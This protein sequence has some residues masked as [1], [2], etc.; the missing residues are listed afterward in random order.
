MHAIILI[1]YAFLTYVGLSAQSISELEQQP[2]Q[3][4]SEDHVFDPSFD[5]FV[6]DLLR[7]LHV[8][9]LSVA[10]VDN[11]KIA[12]KVTSALCLTPCSEPPLYQWRL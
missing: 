2:I 11:G 5:I 6:E 12:S 8:P 7:E 4:S 10:V 9:G 1:V 3:P